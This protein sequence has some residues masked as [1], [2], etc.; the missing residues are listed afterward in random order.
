VK[1]QA[2]EWHWL[3]AHETIAA[4][5][6]CRSCRISGAELNELVEYG[7]LQPL[8][9]SQGPV[10]SAEWVSPLREAARLRRAFDLDLFTVSLVL[11]YLNRIEVLEREVSSLRAHLPAHVPSPGR[12]THE[13]PASWREPHAGS[14]H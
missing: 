6:L 13:G 4:P 14:D 3:D 2:S 8:T 7:A 9:S 5:E 1:A 11:E 12:T 10:F